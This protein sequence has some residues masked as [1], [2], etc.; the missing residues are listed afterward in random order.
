MIGDR[1]SE[2]AAFGQAKAGN[3]RAI[4]RKAGKGTGE[5]GRET[6][7]AAPRLRERR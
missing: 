6:G 5:D 1:A 4:P 2:K 3:R 7:I